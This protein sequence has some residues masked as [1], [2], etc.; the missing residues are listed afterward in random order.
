MSFVECFEFLL[1]FIGEQNA[2]SEGLRHEQFFTECAAALAQDLV[3]GAWDYS[4]ERKYEIVDQLDVQEVGGHCIRGG[5]GAELL[6]VLFR[7][8]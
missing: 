6:R 4:A 2:A 7:I 8:G 5:V 1:L 3:R